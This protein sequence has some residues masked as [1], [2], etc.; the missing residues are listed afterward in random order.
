MIAIPKQ[1]SALLLAAAAAAQSGG[2]TLAIAHAIS[3]DPTT[4]LPALTP[5]DVILNDTELDF[6]KPGPY[7]PPPGIPDFTTLPIP[8]S[9]DV[10][11]MSIGLDWVVTNAAGQVSIPPGHWAA[12]SFSTSR[13]TAGLPG[14]LIDSETTAPGGS[15][16][17][18]FAYILPGSALPPAVVGVPF[19]AQDS[20]EISIDS[21]GMPGNVD[22]HDIFISLIY[23]ENPQLAALLPAPTLYF[24]VTA[25]SLLAAPATITS[26]GAGFESAA[27]IY[28]TT[29]DPPTSTWL[30]VTVAYAPAVLGLLA[31]ED[32]DGLAVDPVRGYFLFS[33]DVA[34]P[35][36]RDQLLISAIGSFANVPYTLPN[37]SGPVKTAIGLGSAPDDI[38]GVCALDPGIVGSPHQAQLHRIIG[39]PRQAALPTAPTDLSASLVR[40]H[41]VLSGTE[42]L[43]SFMTGWPPG[44][45]Q[46]GFAACAVT[47]GQPATGPYVT[48]GLTLR[49][50]VL[51]QYAL[52]DGHPERCEWQ[53]PAG[54]NHSNVPFTFL[55]VAADSA[56]F[57]L[58]HPV[59][60]RL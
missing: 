25:A 58:S 8:A 23:R 7:V 27:T 12:I 38:D 40:R 28:K 31:S 39:T 53:L 5:A 9:V 3:V 17:D 14:S 6:A 16:G 29:W 4:P 45:P 10:D 24:S 19:R 47:I 59:T 51:S 2:P 56:I 35:P 55:W 46:P 36:L 49:P 52:F 15:A 32:I 54:W 37:D 1:A 21:P 13:A 41:D 11:A 42:S 26:W 34:L 48:L 22:A 33:T 20:T 57:T 43:I 44:G 50:N 30:P 18:I 60:V